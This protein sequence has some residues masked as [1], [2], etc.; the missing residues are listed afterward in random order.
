MKLGSSISLPTIAT[1]AV[2][3]DGI[4]NSGFE[5]FRGFFEFF[6]EQV[7]GA[8]VR[9]K[10]ENRKFVTRDTRRFF[11]SVLADF[12]DKTGNFVL[13]L[14]RFANRGVAHVDAEMLVKGLQAML[15][16]LQDVV[17][18]G[19]FVALHR[20]VA[21]GREKSLVRTAAE[22]FDVF[23]KAVH[24]CARF[25]RDDCVKEGKSAFERAFEDCAARFAENGAEIVV[26]HFRAR[27]SRRAKSYRKNTRQVE[28]R[29]GNLIANVSDCLS[30]R[31]LRLLDEF[32]V[33]IF[34]QVL[35]VDEVF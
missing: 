28:Q 33:G 13:F 25:W 15:L 7:F 24:H 4:G 9:R 16:H 29:F 31:I 8:A 11:L 2:R 3:S 32:V 23:G 22:M 30:S 10:T 12:G 26:A 17:F 5:F 27:C 34:Q 20:N 21:V 1:R 35:K 19:H 18:E 14:N 6:D